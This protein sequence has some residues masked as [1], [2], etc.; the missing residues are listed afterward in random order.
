MDQ[1]KED[2]G[3]NRC[4]E[5]IDLPKSTSTTDRTEGLS[6]EDQ[7][8][9]EHIREII[10]E[11]PPRGSYTA[12]AGFSQSLRSEPACESTTGRL[13][14]LLSEH[15]LGLPRQV[16]KRSPSPVEK[17]LEKASGQLNLVAGLD[18]G[19]LIQAH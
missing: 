11:H 19:P 18:P 7:K 4:L 1:H 3:L 5:A 15:E 13:R 12:T 6:E 14:R 9:M 10:D 8:L 17:I 2:R 16:S